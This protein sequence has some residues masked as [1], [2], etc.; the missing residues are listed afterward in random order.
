MSDTA[1][2]FDPLV[3]NAYRHLAAAVLRAYYKDRDTHRRKLKQQ[4]EIL[5]KRLENGSN[6]ILVRQV[7]TPLEAWQSWNA[8]LNNYSAF[9][10]F[11]KSEMYDFYKQFGTRPKRKGD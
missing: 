9:I 10:E 4:K 8:S 1:E 11:E 6:K 3:Y 7:F 5:V 2:D